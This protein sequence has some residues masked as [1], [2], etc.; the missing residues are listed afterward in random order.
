M[1]SLDNKT[2]LVNCLNNDTVLTALYQ[3]IIDSKSILASENKL[4]NASDI[5]MASLDAISNDK[6]DLF[7]SAYNSLS[8]REPNEKSPWIYDDILIFVVLLGCKKYFLDS[9]HIKKLLDLRKR[10]ESSELN[11]ISIAFSNITNNHFDYL[12]E[13]G[14]LYWVFDYLLN[15]SIPDEEQ[16]KKIY[17]VIGQKWN[18]Y[19]SNI[20]LRILM[21]KAYDL[22][23]IYFPF[24]SK[25]I[26]HLENFETNFKKQIRLIANAC[27]FI[28]LLSIF[29]LSI[30]FSYQYFKYP[31]EQRNMNAYYSLFKNIIGYGGIVSILLARKKIILFFE[32]ILCKFFGNKI[33]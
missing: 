3:F 4:G 9:T 11:H 21:T 32:N 10:S 16:L 31:E 6:K 22:F 8:M 23:V 33:Y 27:Y 14:F 26:I 17:L 18:H 25:K 19:K 20:F 12:S 29:V 13:L 5:V 28:I 24:N 2:E 15:K 30:L 7:I 1:V